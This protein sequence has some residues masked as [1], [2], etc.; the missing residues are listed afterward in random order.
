MPAR[1]PRAS[2]PKNCGS[3][4]RLGGTIFNALGC[5][6]VFFSLNN[7]LILG[8][9][10]RVGVFFNPIFT[11]GSVKENGNASNPSCENATS[12]SPQAARCCSN[13]NNSSAIDAQSKRG[14]HLNRSAIAVQQHIIHKNRS[15]WM[16][17]SSSKSC[18]RWARRFAPGAAL[19]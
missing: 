17:L 5:A 14:A 19:G 11:R 6:L 18:S 7:I 4:S 16:R 2:T 3:N 10:T 15:S 1:P 13:S 9:H 8:F 12:G